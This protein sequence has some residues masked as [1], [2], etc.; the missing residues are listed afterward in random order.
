[1]AQG[2]LSG[3]EESGLEPL[4]C[5]KNAEWTVCQKI[6]TEYLWKWT[7]RKIPVRNTN[8][9]QIFPFLV[10]IF[11]VVVVNILINPQRTWHQE[12]DSS[13][14]TE[15]TPRSTGESRERIS[16]HRTTGEADPSQ[17]S[18]S[19]VAKPAQAA[20]ELLKLVYTDP[21]PWTSHRVGDGFSHT[22]LLMPTCSHSSA[23]LE[24]KKFLTS[25]HIF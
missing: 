23:S 4:H 10:N 1:M 25:D 12:T 3:R 16:R 2:L 6:S 22:S 15:S 24:P 8:N 13:P 9:S 21:A 19:P 18:P 11:F 7:V 20:N 17:F 5:R 14:I